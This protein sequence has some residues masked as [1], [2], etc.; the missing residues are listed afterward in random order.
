MADFASPVAASF[1]QDYTKQDMQYFCVQPFIDPYTKKKF[2]FYPLDYCASNYPLY[3][4]TA[5]DVIGFH[6]SMITK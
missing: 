1:V 4:I 5:N 2:L 3:L 6:S